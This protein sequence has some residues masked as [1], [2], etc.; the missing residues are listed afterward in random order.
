MNKLGI[1][2]TIVKKGTTFEV[3]NLAQLG[4]PP[5]GRGKSIKEAVGDW[6]YH[7]QTELGITFDVTAV[8]AD[9]DKALAAD[10]AQR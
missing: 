1:N 10:L 6:L 3:D 2:L 5:I 4:S 7:N 9:V 8:Q